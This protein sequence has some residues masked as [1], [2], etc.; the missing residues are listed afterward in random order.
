LDGAISNRPLLIC[1]S[2]L[3]RLRSYKQTL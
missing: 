1:L 3:N 2:L